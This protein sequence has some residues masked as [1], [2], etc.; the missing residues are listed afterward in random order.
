MTTALPYRSPVAEIDRWPEDIASSYRAAGY[1]NNENF[2]RFWRAKV[3]EFAQRPA[4]VGASSTDRRGRHRLSYRELD[5]TVGRVAAYLRSSGV[6]AG[7]RVIVQL[8]NTIEYVSSVLALFRIGALP[9]FAL[10]AHRETELTQF[11]RI[12]DAT[13]HIVAA[14]SWGTDMTSV[15]DTVAARLR[16]SG[17]EP[18]LIIDTETWELP[19]EP[20]TEHSVATSES[21]A[22]LQLSG[23]TTG[24]PKLIPRT[25]A[26]YLYSVRESASICGLTRD[27]SLLVALPAA[28]NFPMSSPG[29]LGAF[30]HGGKVVLAPDPSPRTAFALIESEHVTIA[31]LVPPLLQSWLAA[32]TRA[33]FDLSSLQTI[34]VGGAKLADTVA[35]RVLPELGAQLQQVF[36]MAEGMVCYTRLDDPLDLVTSTQGRPISPADEVRIVDDSD[37]DVRPGAEGHLLVR[38]PYTIRGYYRAQAQNA[39]AFTADGF[40][41]TGDLVRQLESGHL[42]VTGRAKDQIN[43]GGEKIATDEVE[44]LLLQHPSVR[45]AALIGLPDQ[46]LGERSCAVV[47]KEDDSLAESELRAFFVAQGV[48]DFKVPDSFEFMDRFPETGVG[49]TSRRQLRKILTEELVRSR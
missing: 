17:A 29:I 20:F 37:R 49:K 22:F 19:A 48:A 38:G 39:T 43:R 11:C 44:D 41:R 30:A 7:D 31:S 40:Y 23:G 25:A 36:G 26:D 9:V 13:A 14:T 4:L 42:I 46:Y 34:G 18:P 1:W 33:R 10:P 12:A 15:T 3:E 5:L 16:S 2:D 21:V 27:T 47:I 6:T 8:P 24:I 35:R 32:S 45:D 28:H